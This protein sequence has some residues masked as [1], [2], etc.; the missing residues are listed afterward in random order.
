MKTYR[1]E[2]AK[3]RVST[4]NLC[5][6][7]MYIGHNF[8]KSTIFYPLPSQRSISPLYQLAKKKGGYLIRQPPFFAFENRINDKFSSREYVLSY[9][10]D[11]VSRT[12]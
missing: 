5:K 4:V 10:Q 6:N 8:R 9:Q 1:G 2:D 7:L 3:H 12:I 11:H